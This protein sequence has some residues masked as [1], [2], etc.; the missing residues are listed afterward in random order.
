MQ[1]LPCPARTHQRD[2]PEKGICPCTKCVAEECSHRPGCLYNGRLCTPD[3]AST[4]G[5]PVP[6]DE[7]TSD[8]SRVLSD[9][10]VASVAS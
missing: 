2:G 6:R 4:I 3:P 1:T 10:F 9:R 7:A 5:F 8:H